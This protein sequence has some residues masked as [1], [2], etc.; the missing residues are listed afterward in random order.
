M[1]ENRGQII[2]HIN[3]GVSNYEL[4]KHNF[5]KNG[6]YCHWKLEKNQLDPA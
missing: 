4:Q 3:Y 6:N 1:F 5:M 2:C